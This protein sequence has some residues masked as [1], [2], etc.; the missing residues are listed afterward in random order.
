MASSAPTGDGEVR[1]GEIGILDNPHQRCVEKFPGNRS[2]QTISG[3]YKK[4]PKRETFVNIIELSL[5]F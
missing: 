3:N 1:E 5:V 2:F 4:E